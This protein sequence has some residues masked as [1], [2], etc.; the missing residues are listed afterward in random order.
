MRKIRKCVFRVTFQLIIGC[1]VGCAF[2]DNNYYNLNSGLVL[3]NNL[4][5]GSRNQDKTNDYAIEAEL[6][7][8]RSFKLSEQSGMVIHTSA[9][10]REQFNYDDLSQLKLNA[11]LR[12]RIQPVVSFTSP[13]IEVAIDVNRLNY[14]DSK[15]RD[16]WLSAIGLNVGKNFTDRI[17]VTTGWRYE[18]RYADH[19]NV[20]RWNHNIFKVTGDYQ[21]NNYTRIYGGFSRIYGD[22]IST[23]QFPSRFVNYENWKG[24]YNKNYFNN[25]KAFDRD[26]AFENGNNIHEA[27]R[28]DAKT[29]VIELTINYAVKSDLAVDLNVRQYKSIINGGISYESLNITIGT[30]YQF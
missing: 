26:T 3:D 5:N 2:A 18:S 16:G 11:G 14:R 23:M 6:V 19:S 12:Y 1:N 9:L 4:S 24:L 25:A 30:L 28:V 22:Q 27:Y 8:S 20:Y 13:W 21:F 17:S 7:A 29:N 15:I 10:V